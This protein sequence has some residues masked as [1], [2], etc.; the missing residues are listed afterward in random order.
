[1]YNRSWP[2]CQDLRLIRLFLEPYEVFSELQNASWVPAFV[3]CIALSLLSNLVVVNAIGVAVIMGRFQSDARLKTG[4]SDVF[5]GLYAGRAIPMVIG[6]LTIS[7]V[8]WVVLNLRRSSVAETGAET[9]ARYRI[10]FTICSYA[11][12]RGRPSGS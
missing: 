10:V 2:G 7:I 11:A 8:M 4:G 5:V 6:L 12:T 3:A 9:G 1:M